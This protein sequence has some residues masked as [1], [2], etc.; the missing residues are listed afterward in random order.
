[1]SDISLNALNGHYH[2]YPHL[3]ATEEPSL[4]KRIADIYQSI[5]KSLSQ[6]LFENGLAY[7]FE[8]F[9]GK[10]FLYS[11]FTVGS[12]FSEP[13]TTL[14]STITRITCSWNT[15]WEEHG[16]YDAGDSNSLERLETQL[17]SET[18]SVS[19]R[20]PLLLLHAVHDTPH[21]WLAWAPELEE[22]ERKNEIGHVITLELPNEMEDQ[23]RTANNAIEEITSIYRRVLKHP[24]PQVDLIGHSRGG[25]TGHLLAYNEITVTDNSIMRRWHKIDT[26]NPL[27]RKVVTL[28][29]PTWLCCHGQKNEEGI[30]LYPEKGQFTEQQ[31][32]T[33]HGSHPNVFDI[34]GTQDAIAFERSGLPANQVFQVEHKHKGLLACPDV[35]KLAIS[36]L[37]R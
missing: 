24:L 3:Q 6:W 21:A 30:G 16:F 26:Q 34:I 11:H 23:L 31:L 33:I 22:A 7:Q 25:Y 37:N 14:F 2:C 28:G 18:N 1:M 27:V 36:I 4:C 15:V 35:C 5:I 9:A 20:P 12:F 8:G 17:E 10:F 29:S 19:I 32:G 13:L